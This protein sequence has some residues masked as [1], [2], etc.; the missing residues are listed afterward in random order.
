MSWA[1]LGCV[2]SRRLSR[3]PGWH[4][5]EMSRRS[6]RVE[7]RLRVALVVVFVLMAPLFGTLVG[8]AAYRS[9]KG[10][11]PAVLGLLCALVLIGA[12]VR[13]ALNRKRMRA[14]KNEW[15]EIGPRWT[16]HR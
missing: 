11:T 3:R 2:R 10:Q 12:S 9:E 5:N 6:D 16:R 4:R 13:I 1:M 14:W 7:R 8:K 15:S